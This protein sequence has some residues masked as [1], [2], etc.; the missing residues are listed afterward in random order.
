MQPGRCRLGKG[1]GFEVVRLK[2][3]FDS[4]FP[5]SEW[6]YLRNGVMV[7]TDRGALVHLENLMFEPVGDAH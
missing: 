5:K 2:G 7:E 4:G 3:V 6:E 1:E